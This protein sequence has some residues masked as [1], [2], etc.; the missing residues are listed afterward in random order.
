MIITREYW[1]RIIQVTWLH[2]FL[3]FHLISE[4]ARDF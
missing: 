3:A 2:A 1:E 4:L